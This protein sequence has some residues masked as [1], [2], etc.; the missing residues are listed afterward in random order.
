MLFASN[1]KQPIWSALS[2]LLFWRLKVTSIRKLSFLRFLPEK[3][4]KTKKFNEADFCCL[5]KY[6]EIKKEILCSPL[7][8]I[9]HHYISSEMHVS[10]LERHKARKYS[11]KL[12]LITEQMFRR[13]NGN[14]QCLVE[15]PKEDQKILDR[16]C[17]ML[18]HTSGWEKIK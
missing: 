15:R 12:F 4:W 18:W 6:S 14:I 13:N 7:H 10:S 16:L 17:S 5:G 1:K 8:E 2:I 9:S 11:N 3:R